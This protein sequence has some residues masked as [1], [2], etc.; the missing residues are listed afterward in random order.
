M[1]AITLKKQSLRTTAPS[2]GDQF[3]H[4]LSLLTSKSDS[5]RRDSLAYLTTHVSSRP[6]GS[7]LPLPLSMIMEKLNP[8][9]L[10]GN[11]NVR[12]Q[13]LKLFKVLPRQNIGDE[14]VRTLP[15]VRAG[16][17]HL[18]VDIRLS[19]TETLSWLLDVAGDDVVNCAGGFVKT[20]KSLLASMGWSDTSPAS[21][22]TGIEGRPMAT[23]LEA[24]KKFLEIGIGEEPDEGNSTGA[25]MYSMRP[26]WHYEQHRIPTRSNAYAYLGLFGPPPDADTQM[27]IDRE[28]RRRV[29]DSRFRATILGGLEN[30]RQTGGEIGRASALVLKIVT[31]PE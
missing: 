15:Y 18:A 2:S 17:T 7:A 26:F 22:T 21:S 5:Q 29:F 13:L 23:R 9:I 25:P 6:V 19:A 3:D 16:M 8:L 20:L 28:E 24:L 14:V 1:Q 27:L 12:S 30:G 31:P 4:H 11:R 10:D